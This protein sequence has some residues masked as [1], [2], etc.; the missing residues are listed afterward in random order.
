MD[1]AL[2]QLQT[3]TKEEL[4][5]TATLI[6]RGDVATLKTYAQNPESNVLQGMLASIVL[7]AIEKGDASAFDLLLNRLI[8]KAKDHVEYEEKLSV[9]VVILP[10]N[11]RETHSQNT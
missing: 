8:G 6:L 11:G 7:R 5:E 3:L 2:R 10:S 4:L 1:P 9:P